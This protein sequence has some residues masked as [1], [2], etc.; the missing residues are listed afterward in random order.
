MPLANCCR[1]LRSFFGNTS[2]DARTH[3]V[4]FFRYTINHS[5]RHF[6][7]ILKKLRHCLLPPLSADRPSPTFFWTVFSSACVETFEAEFTLVI[8]PGFENLKSNKL[9]RNGTL[10]RMLLPIQIYSSIDGANPPLTAA[11]HLLKTSGS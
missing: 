3:R 5:T 4:S 7:K 11:A 2:S 6:C 9:Y 10:I 8:L 1:D